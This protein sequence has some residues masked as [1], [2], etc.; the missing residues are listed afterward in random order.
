MNGPHVTSCVEGGRGREAGLVQ[1][2]SPLDA[3][4]L[5]LAWEMQKIPHL[6]ITTRVGDSILGIIL[7]SNCSI[8]LHAS[9]SIS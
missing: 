3:V 8:V 7:R 9:F 6:V 1:T 5:K 4:V 2:P